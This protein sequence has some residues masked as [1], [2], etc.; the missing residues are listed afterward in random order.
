MKTDPVPPRERIAPAPSPQRIAPAAP[1]ASP[2][3]H[4]EPRPAAS[5]T[6]SPPAAPRG[7]AVRVLAAVGLLAGG[8]LLGA[9][10]ERVEQIQREA[11]RANAAIDRLE[12][13]LSARERHP[14]WTWDVPALIQTAAT[15][16][17]SEAPAPTEAPALA[18]PQPIHDLRGAG[19]AEW[20]SLRAR[21]RQ[22][23]DRVVFDVEGEA[24]ELPDGTRLLVVLQDEQGVEASFHQ[25]EVEGERFESARTFLDQALVPQRHHVE[26]R[27]DLRNQRRSVHEVIRRSY[28]LPR[29]SQLSVNLRLNL[30]DEGQ[31]RVA[32]LEARKG[33]LRVVQDLIAAWPNDEST[34]EQLRA[35]RRLLV[36]S[37][38]QQPRYL[39]DPCAEERAQLREQI[40]RARL[41]V[42]DRL[43]GG[44]VTHDRLRSACEGIVSLLLD[45]GHT[46]S[47]C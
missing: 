47:G 43:A 29:D 14:T 15:E 30:G 34:P 26:L 33:L 31:Q 38:D 36:A 28:G 40:A 46:G 35:F 23:E 42:R 20:V 21:L 32:K 3:A 44:V 39:L 18:E 12:A 24:R 8:A 5:V 22:Y 10:H 19:E 9:L 45:L 11:E 37:A 6:V 16:A 17:A 2:P 4:D 25:V 41:G 7:R 27:L 1:P 13:G